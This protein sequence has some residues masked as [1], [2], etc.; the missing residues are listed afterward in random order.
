MTNT[1]T[2]SSGRGNENYV[3]QQC[4]ITAVP[5]FWAPGTG[6]V[7][8]NFSTDWGWAGSAHSNASDGEQ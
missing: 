5:S 2:F 8:D 3:I 1:F 6:L 4:P 7:K